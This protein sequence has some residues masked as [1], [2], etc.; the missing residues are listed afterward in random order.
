MSGDHRLV[1]TAGSDNGEQ[2][3]L[4]PSRCKNGASWWWLWRA[5]QRVAQGPQLGHSHSGGIFPLR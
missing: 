3:H 1:E 2:T 4:S 5:V